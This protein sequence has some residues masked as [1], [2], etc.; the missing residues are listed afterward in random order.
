V[1]EETTPAK[2][3]KAKKLGT[4]QKIGLGVGGVLVVYILYR[5]YENRAASTAATTAAGA[6]DPLTGQ[7][8]AAGVG[9]LAPGTDQGATLADP[10]ID[11]STGQTWASEIAAATSAGGIDPLTG[12]PYS[13]E[14]GNAGIDPLTGVP[15]S[16]EL[17]TS[18]GETSGLGA[19][20]A[21]YEANPSAGTL[22]AYNAALTAL[23]ITPASGNASVSPGNIVP[24][25]GGT[26]TETRAALIADV[27]KATGLSAAQAGQ[28]V[29]LYLEAKPLTSTGAVNSIGNQVKAGLAPTTNGSTTLPAPV[30]AKAVTQAP[31]APA[32][33]ANTA[34]STS[35]K[36]LAASQAALKADPTSAADKAAVAAHQA[37]IARGA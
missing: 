31:A 34:L 15:Y 10:T 28:Q 3:K 17:A 13:S 37:Q 9:S 14:L 21:A 23:G 16:Q 4:P 36:N 35:E 32:A 33:A 25:A 6:T 22:A 12:E 19:A 27:Q 2:K 18:S 7:P 29:A 11:P 26:T 8:Y 1:A 24:G 5:W 20:Y 30:L